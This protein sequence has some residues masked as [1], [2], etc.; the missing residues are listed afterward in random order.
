MVLASVAQT[1][2][3]KQLID[4]LMVVIGDVHLKKLV[5][6]A[7][8]MPEVGPSDQLYIVFT[9]GSTGVPKGVTTTHSN[10]SSAIRHQQ[11][12][13]GFKNTSRVYDFVKYAFDVTWSNFLHTMTSGGC[14]CI[15]SET[16]AI[17]NLA[18]SFL[19]YRA[20]FVDLTPS[21]ASTIRPANLP[22]LNH[23]LFSGEVLYTHIGAQWAE[24]ATVLNTYGPA[25]CSV[26]ATFA[27]IG[28]TEAQVANIGRGFGLCTWIVQPIN[29]DKLVPIGVVG[30][31]LLE[32]PLI[33]AG[34]LGDT[35]RTQTAFIENPPWLVRELPHDASS[36]APGHPGR[37]GRLYKTGDLVRYE[38]DGTMTF[39]GRNN[40]QVKINGQRVELGDVEC[41]VRNNIAIADVQVQVF[42]EILTPSQSDISILMVFIH[43]FNERHADDSVLDHTGQTA[44]ILTG[45]N[46]RL[47]AHVSAYT[48]PSAYLVLK[49]LPMTTTGKADRRR[50]RE[51]GQKL[52]F[53]QI[54]ALSSGSDGGQLPRTATERQLR[55]LW[56][57][58]LGIKTSETIKADHKLEEIQS[59]P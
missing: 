8:E 16:E 33:G 2:L 11:T 28:E 36:G 12:S 34:Y 58:V 17:D 20:N 44:R 47:A 14:L 38:P 39:V 30:E 26:K 18:D 4:R 29:H 7:V 1:E 48:I 57:Q 23:L 27:R 6:P 25:E 54:M 9:S 5:E 32:G 59:Q 3:A 19:K 42:A 35:S 13:M 15:P 24:Q 43:V 45:L 21:A 37:C 51:I 22:T 10:F 41:H 50:L 53:E 52:A 55:S 56:T 46:E 49:E 40:A 31:L